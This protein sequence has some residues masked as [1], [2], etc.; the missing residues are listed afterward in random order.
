[1][2]I[3]IRAHKTWPQTIVCYGPHAWFMTIIR[4]EVLKIKMLILLCCAPMNGS[5]IPLNV[6]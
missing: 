5:L 2:T 1:M 3:A 6:L 4:Y